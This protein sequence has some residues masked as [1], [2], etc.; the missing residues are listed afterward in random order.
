MEKKT[1]NG[2]NSN[3]G[4]LMAA[5]GSAV[6][7]GN[8]WSFPYKM[9]NMGGFVFL[10]CYLAF[11]VLVGY[12][13]LLGEF[14]IGRK[15]QKAAIEG[16]AAVHPSFKIFGIIETVA[17][18]FLVAFYC[19]FGGYVTKYLIASI[20]WMLGI[21]DFGVA[22]AFFEGFVGGGLEPILYMALFW[23]LTVLIV[24]KGTEGIEK[25]C[26]IAIP[27]L[28][29]CMVIVIIRAVTLPGA[30]EG[31]AFIFKPSLEP[32]KGT[33]WIGV[34]GAAGNQCFF[35]LSLASGCLIAYGAGLSKSEN[36]EKNAAIVAIADT[37]VAVMAG[38]TIFPAVFALGLEPNAGPGLLFVTLISVFQGMGA[39]GPIFSVIFF[40]L[41][42]FAALSS[43]IGMMEGGIHAMVDYQEKKGKANR[44]NCVILTAA[45]ALAGNLI[46]AGD[47]LGMTGWWNPLTAVLGPEAGKCWL[48]FFD[49]F[50]EGILMPLG[51]LGMAILLGWV[52]KN[53]LDDEVLQGSEYKT[54]AFVDVCLK[55]IDP[56]ICF[57]LLIVSLDGFFNFTELF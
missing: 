36:L 49:L 21:S 6:G 19:T 41:V 9:G 16:F 47:G 38:V 4:F 17:P 37:C 39:I 57:I 3:F 14:A 24:I 31:L 15:S 42:F 18:Y 13:L 44:M 30:G 12:P 27:A 20:T 10:A 26:K 52:R 55:Y 32:F 51:S 54:K 33:G 48:D 43:S 7:L 50:A 25:F 11:L 5:I 8:L 40:L 53:Y 35:S 1:N 56:V 29:L 46:V 45:I 2:F 28:V 23:G 34:L 22:G